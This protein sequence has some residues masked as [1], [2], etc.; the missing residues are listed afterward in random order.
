[1]PG[2]PPGGGSPLPA[3]CDLEYP[4]TPQQANDLLVKAIAG[5]Y[6]ALLT[7]NRANCWFYWQLETRCPAEYQELKDAYEAALRQN[8]LTGNFKDFTCPQIGPRQPSTPPPSTV[9]PP[10]SGG[11]G[12]QTKAAVMV[13]GQ[14]QNGGFECRESDARPVELCVD[15]PAG[16][17]LYDFKTQ[18][19]WVE[20]ST[21]GNCGV[22]GDC[23]WSRF[24]AAGR[25]GN[26]QFCTQFVNWSHARRRVIRLQIEYE[27]KR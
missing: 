6:D 12:R 5:D 22:G 19:K 9:P 3:G 13:V 26:S 7:L 21:F 16:A 14:C 23:A 24:L 2:G 4:L 11:G 18:I 17:T 25:R 1:L 27:E 10:A 20:D 8:G 15:Y